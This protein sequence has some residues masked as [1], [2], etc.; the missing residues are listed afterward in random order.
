L[1]NRRGQPALATK[2]S[3]VALLGATVIS[4]SSLDP[5][6]ARDGIRFPESL[7]AIPASVVEGR[8][9]LL[10]SPALKAG[11]STAVG[12][13]PTE[14]TSGTARR[15][16]IVPGT[17]GSVWLP[18]GLPPGGYSAAIVDGS[19]G[20]VDFRV[21]PRQLA[22][23]DEDRS[24]HP[25]AIECAHPMVP[26]QIAVGTWETPHDTDYF[27]FVTLAG[28]RLDVELRV[29]PERRNYYP[30]QP[31]LF[32]FDPDGL[33]ELEVAYS[34]GRKGP[35][36]LPGFVANQ[37]GRYTIACRGIRGRGKYQL[38]IS[39]ASDSS[40]PG[41]ASF[42]SARAGPAAV[43]VFS[44]DKKTPPI[45]LAA[46]VF[47]DDGDLVAGM[48]VT[49]GSP[50]R[51][52]RGQRPIPS[53]VLGV[54]ETWFELKGGS[55]A[56]V[57]P[58]F[59]EAQQGRVSR[60]GPFAGAVTIGSG[61]RV[62]DAWIPTRA[63]IRETTAA[64]RRRLQIEGA[65][66]SPAPVSNSPS[67]RVFLHREEGLLDK[68]H[69]LKMER[70]GS[71]RDSGGNS[72]V[73]PYEVPIGR[74]V[75][76][77][78]YL[79][80]EQEKG[81]RES[82]G[83]ST[84]KKSGEDVRNHRPTVV[85]GVSTPI[86]VALDG[87]QGSPRS[88]GPAVAIVSSSD[89]NRE[90]IIQVDGGG[91]GSGFIHPGRWA[92]FSRFDTFDEP[93]YELSGIVSARMDVWSDR[94][95]G[96][97]ST[98]ATDPLRARPGTARRLVWL[99]R[100]DQ[101]VWCVDSVP[102]GGSQGC[103]GPPLV[104][105]DGFDNPIAAGLR[106]ELRAELI[107]G[108]ATGTAP[109]V[110]F[111]SDPVTRPEVITPWNRSVDAASTEQPAR[112]RICPES[113][114]GGTV[115]C[116]ELEFQIPSNEPQVVIVRDG[117]EAP[118]GTANLGT[119][120]PGG[121]LTD[122][123]GETSR[124]RILFRT[125][126]GADLRPEKPRVTVRVTGP[127]DAGASFFASPDTP[128]KQL[129][130][131]PRGDVAFCL[132]GADQEPCE[133]LSVLDFSL[134]TMD[135]A[136]GS[137]GSRWLA[138]PEFSLVRGPKLPGNYWL[139]I[140]IEPGHLPYLDDWVG[141]RQIGWLDMNSGVYV[142]EEQR[143]IEGTII[144]NRPRTVWFRGV[145]DHTETRVPMTTSFTPDKDPES[146]QSF[147][148]A[149]RRVGPPVG[150]RA[151]YIGPVNLMPGSR[152]EPPPADLHDQV[153]EESPNSGLEVSAALASSW[154]WAEDIAG[155][156]DGLLSGYSQSVV[157]DG[158]QLSVGIELFTETDNARSFL[159]NT[160][161]ES[162]VSYQRGV[163]GE[164]TD[165]CPADECWWMPPHEGVNETALA[166][167]GRLVVSVTVATAAPAEAR[168]SALRQVLASLD[169]R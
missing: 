115:E 143:V 32:I 83:L 80:E 26:G 10:V 17:D 146:K 127:V 96:W 46:F 58:T 3:I 19:G 140:G 78:T 106:V 79:G 9:V 139:T 131:E 8:P 124:I 89:S 151:L 88:K 77:S 35:A 44:F 67:V 20:S 72:G 123:N 167:F 69:G 15:L 112:W 76:L 57:T 71:P 97:F 6:K 159:R 120:E 111:K 63:Q 153:L 14:G 169:A 70:L 41:G 156:P 24:C 132:E 59:P 103:A 144:T 30:S 150:T 114:S 5:D 53:N 85:A 138:T 129:E 60:R 87:F 117:I 65:A 28:T 160:R 113:S 34:Y 86:A 23:T 55:P 141:H 62:V 12:L 121:P 75:G 45:R 107:S 47:S 36:E 105:V 61:G 73:P 158:I 118:G 82:G 161:S 16:I 38:S 145:L 134:A 101:V 147:M 135:R 43:N 116:G 164:S 56:I 109:H 92:M 18:H 133:G 142:N 22:L 126:P 64:A 74:A 7:L 66:H 99:G 31:E 49:W 27:T 102:A 119:I 40:S 39:H 90:S 68:E 2:T 42:V 52:I 110:E 100:P 166:R 29:E 81:L 137:S 122:E 94:D 157:L 152:A 51:S 128:W 98:L 108:R 95:Q 4:C 136:P 1:R 93:V 84:P 104:I 149:G 125:P 91:R 130:P 168:H 155:L 54:A 33:A 50:D 21:V 13:T 154:Y 165:G 25:E 11:Q 162:L 48:P 37:T 163:P 148:V